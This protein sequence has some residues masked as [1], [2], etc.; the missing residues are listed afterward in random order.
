MGTFAHR[1]KMIQAFSI[2]VGKSLQEEILETFW[3]NFE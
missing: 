1:E 2:F 3:R